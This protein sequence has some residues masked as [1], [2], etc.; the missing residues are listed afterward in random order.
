[1]QRRHRTMADEA[2]DH[3]ASHLIK[4]V[5]KNHKKHTH[6]LDVRPKM[7]TSSIHGNSKHSPPPLQQDYDTKKRRADNFFDKKGANTFFEKKRGKGH[8]SLIFY[9][10]KLSI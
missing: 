9:L 5:E 8:F 6:N 2:I 1:M 3:A 4:K 7:S 10:K